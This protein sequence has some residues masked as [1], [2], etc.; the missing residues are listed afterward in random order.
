MNW[1]APWN[2][3]HACDQCEEGWIWEGAEGRPCP[4]LLHATAVFEAE[5]RARLGDPPEAMSPMDDEP[6]G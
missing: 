6:D 1:I 3:V 5:A 2:V 4:G